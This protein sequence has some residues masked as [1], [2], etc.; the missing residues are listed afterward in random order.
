MNRSLLVAPKISSRI[1]SPIRSIR[2]P[3]VSDESMESRGVVE[4][5]FCLLL[6]DM[7][8]MK[9]LVGVRAARVKR[10]TQKLPRWIV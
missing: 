4:G 7:A 10:E 5:D 1:S 9:E 2:L 8:S 3:T 6:D